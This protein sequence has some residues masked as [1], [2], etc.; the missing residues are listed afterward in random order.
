[1][2]GEVVVQ[3][4]QEPLVGAP[5]LDQRG[6]GLAH[7]VGDRPALDLGD[8]LQALGQARVEAQQQVLGAPWLHRHSDIKISPCRYPA[9]DQLEQRRQ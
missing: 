7:D 3:Q 1:V 2:P 6:D 4:P 8:R 5:L 9:N